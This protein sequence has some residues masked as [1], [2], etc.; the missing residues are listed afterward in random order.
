[1]GKL[2]TALLYEKIMHRV[3]PMERLTRHHNFAMEAFLPGVRKGVIGGLSNTI[4]G[5]L[6][7]SLPFYNCVARI[8]I[9][10]TSYITKILH[11]YLTST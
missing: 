2:Y 8:G 3:V 5:A 1:M 6:F 7:F 10:K 9:R 4:W 11:T